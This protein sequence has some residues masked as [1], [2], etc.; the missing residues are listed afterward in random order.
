[1]RATAGHIQAIPEIV[2]WRNFHS[3]GDQDVG[4]LSDGGDE[5]AAGTS[6][7][8]WMSLR[9]RDSSSR[10]TSV[11]PQLGPALGTALPGRPSAP[12]QLGS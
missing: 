1:M 2:R 5:P 4:G 9:A 3:V 12:I 6:M 7:S 11:D 10:L 8:F